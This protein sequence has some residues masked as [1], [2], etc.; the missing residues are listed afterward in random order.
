MTCLRKPSEPLYSTLANDPDLAELVVFF[1]DE[2]PGRIA[3]L[4]EKLAQE[5]WDGLRRLA[6]QLKGAAG[7]YGFETI[8]EAAADVESAIR[9]SRPED[10]IR[11]YLEELVELCSRATV[12]GAATG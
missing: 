2:M 6:H 7:G 11:R 4:L 1:V 3:C 8:T 5:D 12:A 10:E 9:E